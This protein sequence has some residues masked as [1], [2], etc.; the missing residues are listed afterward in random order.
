MVIYV[1]FPP[2]V[3]ARVS[4]WGR[5]AGDEPTSPVLLEVNST[6]MANSQCK[7]IFNIVIDSQLCISGVGGVGSCRGDS[8]GPLVYDNVQI[9]IV[10]YGVRNCLPGYPSAFTRITSYLDWLEEKTGLKF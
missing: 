1:L 6:V 3:N 2:G 8:G 5:I 7:Q 9:G 4:G 10:S